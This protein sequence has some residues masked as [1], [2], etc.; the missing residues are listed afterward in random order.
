MSI[1]DLNTGLLIRS[2]RLSPTDHRGDRVKSY[3]VRD[4]DFHIST[5]CHWDYS[6]ATT[7]N[8]LISAKAV[9][10]KWNH[11]RKQ[12]SNLKDHKINSE[13]PDMEI[14]T[15]SYDAK[16]YEYIFLCSEKKE[17]VQ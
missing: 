4:Q 11:Y 3:I 17:K 7:D 10:E 1:Y 6:K 2:K 12:P 13:I 15:Y 5:T 9:L 8:Y 16:N 14:H